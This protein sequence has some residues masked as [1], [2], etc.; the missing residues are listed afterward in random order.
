MDDEQYQ[1]ERQA[2]IEAEHSDAEHYDR[3]LLTL[4]AGALGISIAFLKDIAPNPDPS[5]HCWLITAWTSLIAAI[6]ATVGSMQVSQWAFQRYRALLDKQHAGNPEASQRNNPKTVL[7][8]L[9][10]LSLFLFV[11]GISALA[12]FS[13]QNLPGE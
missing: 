9:N 8:W 12:V 2:S 4:S 6:T 5:T 7:Q 10:W 13:F 11:T 1:Q 3:W